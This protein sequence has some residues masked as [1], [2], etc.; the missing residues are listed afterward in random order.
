MRGETTRQE[1][2]FS[3]ISLEARVPKDQPLRKIKR[4]TAHVLVELEDV[5]AGS[6]SEFGRPSIAPEVL[7]KSQLLMA[8]F[9]VPSDRAFCERLNW[10]LLFRWFLDLPID[11][12][13]FDHSVF[14]KNRKRLLEQDVS[15]EFFER[16]VE[17]ARKEN[18][19]SESIL[20]WMARKPNLGRP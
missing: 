8:L 12:S 16:V 18:L 14:S 13:G 2:L 11:A 1:M 6:Y 15:Q 10:D 3:Y 5:L 19:L 7:V 20:R 17:L 4:C 9:S